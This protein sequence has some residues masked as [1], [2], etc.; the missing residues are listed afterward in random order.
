VLP[1]IT[2]NNELTS[3]GFD[4]KLNKHRTITK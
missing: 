3:E 1:S 4:I 2:V